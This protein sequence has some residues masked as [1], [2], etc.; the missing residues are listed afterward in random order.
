M[1][2]TWFFRVR[3]PFRESHLL[4]HVS[5][6]IHQ[7][8]MNYQLIMIDEL[9]TH[10]PDLSCNILPPRD[11]VTIS[12]HPN[13]ALTRAPSSYDETCG[14]FQP[15]LPGQD[16]GR[17]QKAPAD[18]ETCRAGCTRCAAKMAHRGRQRIGVR[19]RYMSHICLINSFIGNCWMDKMRFWTTGLGETQFSEKPNLSMIH[20]YLIASDEGDVPCFW[21]IL[22]D[23]MADFSMNH[24]SPSRSSLGYMCPYFGGTCFFVEIVASNKAQITYTIIYRIY[25]YG[26][27]WK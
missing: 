2:K 4:F 26:F 12:Y 22:T 23:F 20:D 21:A 25:I 11:C 3:A 9:S 19:R 17:A 6:L 7:V 15:R 13:T 18:G 24:I 1:F 8:S 14:A 27:V 16:A 10:Y 5:I